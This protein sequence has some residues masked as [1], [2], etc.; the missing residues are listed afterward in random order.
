MSAI[1]K[2]REAKD[3][4]VW[5][6][7]LRVVVYTVILGVAVGAE[8]VGVPAVP[9]A[10]VLAVLLTALVLTL[11][12][13]GWSYWGSTLTLQAVLQVVVDLAVIT[14]II[15]FTGD[16]ESYFWILY[17]FTI[18]FSS[19]TLY[20]VGAITT[21]V[22]A[23]LSNAFLALLV[24]AA[25][26]PSYAAANPGL[27]PVVMRLLMETFALIV[28]GYISGYLAENLRRKG[29]ELV[30]KTDALASLMAVNENI[31]QSMRGGL[32]TT[33]LEGKA[34]RLNPAGEEILGRYGYEVVGRMV[35]E[36]FPGLRFAECASLLADGRRNVRMDS[37]VPTK[38]GEKYLGISLSP[39]LSSSETRIGYLMN[40][41]DLTELKRL[42][43]EV[44]AKERMAAL[45]E[46]A[47]GLAHEVR[48]PL[49]S[50]AGSVGL[51]RQEISLTED[52]EKLMG[53][54]FQ[55]SQR[56]NKIINDFLIYSRQITYHPQEVDLCELLEDT[57]TLLHNTPGVTEHHRIVKKVEQQP[58]P[59]VLDPDLIKQVLWNL[60][61]NAI[62]A[63]PEGG[64]LTIELS[65]GGNKEV[66]IV[67]RDTGVGIEEERIDKIFE[68]FHSSFA[69]GTGLG[70]AI[71][72]QIIQAHNG[73]INVQ[74][75][76]GK[77]STF[78]V[79]L[80]CPREEKHSSPKHP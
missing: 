59:C 78:E 79:V 61:Q 54:V 21:A 25:V 26:I 64:T 8:H 35:Q 18:A 22:V 9:V 53:I 38:E 47:A 72:Y 41:Q 52:Q 28:V 34:T 56:L 63:M 67:V 49:A 58:F 31:I 42:E 48:N 10:T 16:V 3:W 29:V 32:L 12:S 57:V 30:D 33:D 11:A 14:S 75:A 69:N 68:P 44:R 15:Y 71:V 45:G 20:Q 23:S 5:F 1:K 46:M 19:L 39:L 36:A 6:L 24:Q 4:I 80:P 62:R 2:T 43:R 60:S 40:F 65:R 50:I 77:G 70:L 27:R 74:S 66:R 51:M 55:E 17:F 37:I 7:K 76:V 13:A 73:R